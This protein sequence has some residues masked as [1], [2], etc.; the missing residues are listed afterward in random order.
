[1]LVALISLVG[2]PPNG[3][4]NRSAL[5]QLSL[6]TDTR[7][8]RRDF[9]RRRR[10]LAPRMSLKPSAKSFPSSPIS[11]PSCAHLKFAVF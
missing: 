11:L 8:T 10:S 6:V 4:R 1:M 2:Q 9:V 3:A 5:L 7:H